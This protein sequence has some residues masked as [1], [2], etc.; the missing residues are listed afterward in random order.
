[1]YKVALICTVETKGNANA[2]L[3]RE[4]L[5][6]KYNNDLVWHTVFAQHYGDPIPEMVKQ[7]ADPNLSIIST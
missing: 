2:K 4:N 3:I 5:E 1:M 7:P 6:N